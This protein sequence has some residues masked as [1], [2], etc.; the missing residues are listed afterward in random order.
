MSKLAYGVSFLDGQS[1]TGL[2]SK[3][4][5]KD[6]NTL[7]TI[8]E[9]HAPMVASLDQGFVRVFGLSGEPVEY[10]YQQAFLN[11]HDNAVTITVVE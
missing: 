9:N 11:C 2:A 4:F 6:K 7:M 10:S 8:S 3:I 1:V 5:V